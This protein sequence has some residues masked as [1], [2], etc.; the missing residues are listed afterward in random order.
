[1]FKPTPIIFALL[2]L[3][4]LIASGFVFLDRASVLSSAQSLEATITDCEGKRSRRSARS[5]KG[6]GITR[7]TYA[8]VAV[9][10]EGY[11]VTGKIYISGKQRCER[12]IGRQV[13]ILVDLNNP[14]DARI[15]SFM[16]FWLFPAGLVFAGAM[17]IAIVLMAKGVFFVLFVSGALVIGGGAFYEIWGIGGPSEP[18]APIVVDNERTLDVCLAEARRKEGV[19]QNGQIKRLTCKDRGVSDLTPLQSL[20]RLEYLDIRS[21]KISS[22][23]P[24]GNFHALREIRLDG[25]RLLQTLDGLEGLKSLEVL[26]ARSVQLGDIEALGTL[27]TLREVDLNNNGLSN[28]SALSGLYKLVRVVIDD[29]RELSDISALAGKPDLETVTFY[30]TQVVDISPLYT[31]TKLKRVDIGETPAVPCEQIAYLQ[32]NTQQ[33]VRGISGVERCN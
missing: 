6:G 32:Q 13:K 17:T 18:P 15:N 12:M 8:P 25:N 33:T 4:W 19:E 3:L 2:A 26:S 14:D 7:W 1:M 27:T 24:I 11:K 22:L 21:N 5:S 23:V 30:R 29:N 9:S 10:A 28:I 20:T 16:Q 31:A